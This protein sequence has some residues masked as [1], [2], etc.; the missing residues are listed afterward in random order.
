M[1]AFE[2]WCWRRLLRI[3]EYR[4]EIIREAMTEANGQ[5]FPGDQGQ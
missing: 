4:E 5:E 3:Q 1:Y 2:L